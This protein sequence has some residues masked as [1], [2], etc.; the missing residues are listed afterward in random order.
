MKIL[1][2]ES[3]GGGLLVRS[4]ISLGI[5]IAVSKLVYNLQLKRKICQLFD[6]VSLYSYEIVHLT[7]FAFVVLKVVQ[8]TRRSRYI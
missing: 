8:D 6:T 5:V 7:L 2:T 3:D 4:S 1:E